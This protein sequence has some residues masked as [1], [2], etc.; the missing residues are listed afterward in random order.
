MRKH[1]SEPLHT[2]GRVAASDKISNRD[3]ERSFYSP[4]RSSELDS[5][6]TRSSSLDCSGGA[7]AEEGT[8]DTDA[9]MPI[10]IPTLTVTSE[11]ERSVCNEPTLS[12][13][14]CQSHSRHRIPAYALL[15]QAASSLDAAG[16]T[17][18]TAVHLSAGASDVSSQ[19][20]ISCRTAEVAT[21]P[22]AAPCVRQ[23]T[24]AMKETATAVRDGVA[25]PQK[26][27]TGNSNADLPGKVAGPPRPTPLPRRIKDILSS[28]ISSVLRT[29]RDNTSV[30]EPATFAETL[31]VR[32]TSPTPRI[33]PSTSFPV[34]PTV[35]QST[36][37]T[38]AS[39]TTC[40]SLQRDTSTSRD[41][42]DQATR[43]ATI[44]TSAMA[45]ASSSGSKSTPAKRKEKKATRRNTSL[46][47]FFLSRHRDSEGGDDAASVRSE[48]SGTTDGLRLS[49]IM[50]KLG[51]LPPHRFFSSS[52]TTTDTG[53]SSR[54]TVLPSRY[55]AGDRGGHCGNDANRAS[56]QRA[57]IGAGVSSSAVLPRVWPEPSTSFSV[58]ETSDMESI[59]VDDSCADAL[60]LER[61]AL[62][63]E[64]RDD[65]RRRNASPARSVT[66]GAIAS[67]DPEWYSC[68]SRMSE[69]PPPSPSLARKTSN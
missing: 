12:S 45:E 59:I 29:T 21:S 64:R 30:T 47:H 36:G 69:R 63:R 6:S 18:E 37:K 40:E 67:P 15:P 35:T 53:G 51:I 43:A 34:S 54:E 5:L 22:Q 17:I 11:L 7:A 14:L 62:R 52:T 13:R 55:G 16:T 61:N 23:R 2:R 31:T 44:C 4:F 27:K 3:E 57:V 10:S 24:E 68:S 41:C 48:S 39:A 26:R 60:S 46:P 19:H 25:P 65:Q 8:Y 1:F 56:P 50:A 49:V 33:S 42:V 32:T 66:Y 58:V 28:N 20:E 9:L 38:H